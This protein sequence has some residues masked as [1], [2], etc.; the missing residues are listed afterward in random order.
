MAGPFGIEVDIHGARVVVMRTPICAGCLTDG[1]VDAQIKLLKASLDDA[2]SDMKVAIP[3]Q[4]A[5]PLFADED[6]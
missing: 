3:K 4:L 1:E 2:A 6:D 5:K